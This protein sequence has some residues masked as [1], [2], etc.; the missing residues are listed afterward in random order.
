M[1]KC[2]SRT[3]IHQTTSFHTKEIFSDKDID[4][5][6]RTLKVETQ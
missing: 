3:E 1:Q 5:P 6:H 4:D 2:V